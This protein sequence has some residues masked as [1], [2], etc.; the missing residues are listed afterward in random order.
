MEYFSRVLSS[1]SSMSFQEE[2]ATLKDK[3][4]ELQSLAYSVEDAKAIATARRHVT[5][6]INYMKA[7]S[8][9]SSQASG[10]SF[11]PV[12]RPSSNALQQRNRNT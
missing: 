11:P 5:I 1:S 8:K 4:R 3:V 6:A 10:S 7:C 9:Y 2:K 12:K